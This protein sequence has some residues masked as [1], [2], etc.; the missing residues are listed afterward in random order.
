MHVLAVAAHAARGEV[1]LQAVDANR[2]LV[3]VARDTAQDRVEA[4]DQF[5]RTE[6][7]GH[8]VIGS[9]VQGRDLDVLLADRREDDDRHLGPAT[10]LP[11]DIDPV[12]VGQH[13]IDDRRFG[14]LQRRGIEC[15]LR[16]LRQHGIEAALAQD[17][18]QA[19]QDL[20]LVVADKHA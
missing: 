6:W 16:A 19:T 13:E 7:L 2:G 14:R 20:Q 17:D 15:L 9:R 18:L 12:S 3:D 10:Q 8:V 1:D 4:S 11:T 5:A